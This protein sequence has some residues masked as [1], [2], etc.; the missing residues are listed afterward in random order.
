MLKRKPTRLEFKEADDKEDLEQARKSASA[1]AAA[2]AAASSAGAAAVGG[3]A[4]ATPQVIEFRPKL[5][6][7]QRIGFNK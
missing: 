2:A 4:S 6:V 1:A 3:S 7:A 5:S